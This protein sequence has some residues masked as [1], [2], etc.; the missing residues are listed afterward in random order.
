MLDRA[1]ITV[2]VDGGAIVARPSSYI[3]TDIDAAIRRDKPELVRL[4][5]LAEGL[6]V[7]DDAAR[8]LDSE[9]VD[10][11]A[12]PICLACGRY[13]DVLTLA[14]EWRCSKCDPQ[15]KDRKMLT[16]RLLSFSRA[17]ARATLSKQAFKG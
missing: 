8:L 14:D 7:D 13:S 16:L 15:A 11:E 5:R 6:P 3:T 10:P 1:G 12:V 9:L 2:R 17:S 4:L